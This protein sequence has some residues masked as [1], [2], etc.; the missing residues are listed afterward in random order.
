VEQAH[1]ARGQVLKVESS[2]RLTILLIDER[3]A[4]LANI[5]VI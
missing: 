4:S 1:G 3:R 2:K 5:V